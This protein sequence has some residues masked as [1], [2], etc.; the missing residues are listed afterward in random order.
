MKYLITGGAG[1]IGSHLADALAGTHE[2]VVLDN[3]ATGK[4]GN[5]QHLIEARR[6][7]L[8]RGSVTDPALLK[9]CMEGVDGVFHE[10]A[11]VSVLRSVK[12]PD[13][14]N[15]ANVAGT[16]RVL[17]AARDAGVKAVVF[18]SSSSVYGES[19]VLP[20]REDMP[21]VPKSPYAVSKLAGEHYLRVFSELYGI[22]TVSLRYFNV[23]GPR[24]DPESPY[25]AVIPL[26]ITRVLRGEP[27][28]IHG[29]G[30]QTRD[31]TY[32]KDVVQG[33]LKAMASGA[34]GTFNL[35]CGERNSVLAL[36]RAVME[37]AGK[38][39]PIRHEP[40][41]PGDIRDSL[42]DISAARERLKYAPGYTLRTGLEETVPW[43][44]KK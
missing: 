5:I 17:V 40:P 12:D 11:L 7:S 26:F 25:A 22:R 33:N 36:A 37:I 41:R 4:A 14:T 32:V 10:A 44:M 27:I 2:L 31:F 24:Q 9:T 15:E 34:R 20:K 1:F 29:D 39:V 13:A 19:P 28:V 30:G 42:A 38:E 16:L 43:Y 35:A 8:V 6:V 18:A 21:P 3:L 23:F